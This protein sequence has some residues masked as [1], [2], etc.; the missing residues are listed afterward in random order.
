MAK[1]KPPRPKKVKFSREDIARWRLSSTRT[2]EKQYYY[3][4]ETVLIVDD[5]VEVGK[6]VKSLL[7]SLGFNADF[8]ENGSRAIEQL[9]NGDY[10][11]LITDINMPDLSGIELIKMVSRENPEIS[12]IAMT[13]Y[14][15]DYTYMDVINAGAS[16]FI[17]KPFKIDELEAKIARELMERKTREELNKFSITDNFTY[18][19]KRLIEFPPEYHQAGLSILNY[20]GSIVQQKYPEKKVGIKIQQEGL[21]VIM[22]IES[23]EGDKDIIERTLD[24][25]GLV[26]C[27][28]MEPR[29]FLKDPNHLLALKHKLELAN[30]EIRHT[31]ELMYSE[32]SQ[33]G[34]RVK[35]LESEVERLYTLIGDSLQSNHSFRKIINESFQA[36]QSIT[37]T[38]LKLL[39][40][41]LLNGLKESDKADIIEAF[42]KI[43]KNDPGIF[44]Q[45]F[46][47]II[48]GSISGAAGSFLYKWITIVSSSLPK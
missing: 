31:K 40:R 16:D 5:E 21:R 8:V 28:K 44:E 36:S 43:K 12:I 42:K 18:T 37:K 46:D 11:F 41:R 14:D 23:P 33:F 32:R 4:N 39:E 22:I 10:S 7:T 19:I 24:E 17:V 1:K 9:R 26:I 3:K 35:A 25:Y 30:M 2:M 45:L 47:L 20:F 13:G 29:H 15:K 48:K 6:V 38:A 27:G 34:K